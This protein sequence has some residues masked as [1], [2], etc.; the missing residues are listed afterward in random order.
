MQP[1]PPNSHFDLSYKLLNGL[2]INT[3]KVIMESIEDYKKNGA[4][5]E[6]IDFDP[7]Y[8]PIGFEHYNSI[9]HHDVV[10]LDKTV[11]VDFPSMQRRSVFLTVFGVFEHEIELFCR[12]YA[13]KN[14]LK[15]KVTDFKGSGTERSQ[16]YIKKVIGF[17][18]SSSELSQL[19][20]LRNACAHQDAKYKYSDE[21]VIYEIVMLV[22]EQP[23][24]LELDD[25]GKVILK[26]GFLDWAL[27]TFYC[28]FHD[29]ES[30]LLNRMKG[31]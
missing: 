3:E 5:F 7:E 2:C 31:I 21:Q 10:D 17:N 1:F 30:Q 23:D 20:R 8:G 24:L 29:M 16:L 18:S 26:A 4:T 15:V 6:E 9:T 27:N 19:H 11:M 22:K 12:T 13:K 28:F 25:S 14:N